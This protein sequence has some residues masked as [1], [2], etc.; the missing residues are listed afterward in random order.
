M[1]RARSNHGPC[2]IC[3]LRPQRVHGRCRTCCSFFK[4]TGR[5]RPPGQDLRLRA[6]TCTWDGCGR[7]HRS[8]G[9]CN[10]HYNRLRRGGDMSA[11]VQARSPNRD[12]TCRLT[13]CLRLRRKGARGLCSTHWSRLRDAEIA[14]T[15][16]LMEW[17][18]P[19]ALRTPAGASRRYSV[20]RPY[21]EKLKQYAEDRGLPLHRAGGEVIERWLDEHWA[22]P[23]G[24]R[25]DEQPEEAYGLQRRGSVFGT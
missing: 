17:A 22:G 11:P 20:R 9:L 8:G 3:G 16:E 10:L 1:P 6:S 21:L 2:R 4:R 19:L 14:G 12:G 5:E 23:D 24:G 18:R 15:V 13:T 7:R 25:R